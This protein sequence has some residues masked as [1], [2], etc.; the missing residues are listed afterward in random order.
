MYSDWKS[1]AY[2]TGGKVLGN[3]IRVM[4][5]RASFMKISEHESPASD[6]PS[7]VSTSVPSV[8]EPKMI[9]PALPTAA[10]TTVELRRRL[11]K[12]LYKAELDLASGM[13]IA[14][15]PCD[16]LDHKHGL[17]LEAA[18][19]ELVA[20]DPD[21]SVYQEIIQW[22]HDNH[23]KLTVESIASG[24]FAAE[25]PHMALQFKNFRKTVM[26]SAAK[27]VEVQV[28]TVTSEDEPKEFTLQA[29]KRLAA[30]AAEEEVERQ[31]HSQQ[32]KSEL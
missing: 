16:C 17:Y 7:T 9:G 22:L 12:E 8:S 28:I 1:Q 24:K 29:A 2:S 32:T 25:Y 5:S 6:Q 11:A 26:D 23:E 19:E 13:K 10:E 30:S 31:W 27:P 21:H 14:G 15:K 3:L 4:L 20:Q 18:S